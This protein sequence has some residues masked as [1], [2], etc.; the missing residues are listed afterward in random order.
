MA[1]GAS[2]PTRIAADVAATAVLV[3]PAEN[4]TV[5]EQISYW[6][7]LGMQIERST[8]VAGRRVLAVVGG[9]TQFSTRT[10][11]TSGPSP[12]QRSTPAS[13]NA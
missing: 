9:D 7:G 12:T 10:A 4:R 8:S 11:P 13:Q 3:A 6:A 2:T 1:K 5:T